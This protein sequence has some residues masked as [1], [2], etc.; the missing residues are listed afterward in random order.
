MPLKLVLPALVAAAL[1]GGCV[2]MG[3]NYDPAEVASLEAGMTLPEI[4]RRLGKP[5]S[6]VTLGDGTSQA[7]WLHSTGSMLG[8]SSRAVTLLFDAQ[9]RFIKPL[10]QVQTNLR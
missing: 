1:C 7:M 8:G 3:P 10:N 6:V 2:S 4:A 5:T 9:G